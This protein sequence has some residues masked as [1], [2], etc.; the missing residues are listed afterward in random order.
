MRSKAPV[1]PSV[2]NEIP[3]FTL[4]RVAR[5]R[6]GEEDGEEKC[7]DHS[8]Q[9]QQLLDGWFKVWDRRGF[10]LHTIR[11]YSV[12]SIIRLRSRCATGWEAGAAFSVLVCFVL[13]CVFENPLYAFVA[14]IYPVQMR[15]KVAPRAV[16]VFFFL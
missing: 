6:G 4:L 9:L 11:V 2:C 3:M 13:F 5:Q 10:L 14:C 8:A 1:R 12:Q 16:C 15:H 7:Q